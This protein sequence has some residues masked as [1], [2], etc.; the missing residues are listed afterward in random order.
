MTVYRGWLRAVKALDLI[1]AGCASDQSAVKRWRAYWP[2]ARFHLFEVEPS[3]V[4]MLQRAFGKDPRIVVNNMA[5]SDTV[6][7]MEFYA[8][9]V[10]MISSRMP[11]NRASANFVPGWG[12]ETR[13][14]VETTTL[15]AY[16]D[17]HSIGRIGLIE[18]DV[19][20]GELAALQGAADL[21][22]RKAFDALMVEV[23][24]NELYQGVPLEPTVSD[25]L[26]QFGYKQAVKS[27]LP[28]A[29]WA[30]IV[31]T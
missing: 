14:E 2:L 25:Y 11:F 10:P 6:G 26:A 3:N 1:V 7:T 27:Q 19:Q 18:L 22:K 12:N 16:C 4:A 24:Y 21:L 15:D 5:L 17:A 13:M 23:F 8:N 20:G 31:Y 9:A 28:K 29:G 30:D